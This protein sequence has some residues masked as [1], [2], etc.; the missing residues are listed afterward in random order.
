M[1]DLIRPIRQIIEDHRLTRHIDAQV[2]CCCGA[3]D[4]DHLRDVAEQIRL[5]LKLAHVNGVK[6]QIRYAM[7][8]S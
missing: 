7:A 8:W 2:S 3:K 6:Q 5:S 4:F 1:S